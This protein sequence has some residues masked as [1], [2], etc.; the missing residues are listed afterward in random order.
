[1]RFGI[2]GA[3]GRTITV[4][5]LP[6]RNL[7]AYEV[8]PLQAGQ[9]DQRQPLKN[10]GADE[11]RKRE[12]LG[13]VRRLPLLAPASA[14]RRAPAASF[15]RPGI[16]PLPGLIII[17]IEVVT[18]QAVEFVGRER[19][20]GGPHVEPT[21]QT[22]A[23][24]RIGVQ[25]SVLAGVVHQ[26][27]QGAEKPFDARIGITRMEVLLELAEPCAV[28]VEQLD[29]PVLR[30][31]FDDMEQCLVAGG[32][33][34]FL[35]GVP[36]I[37]DTFFEKVVQGFSGRGFPHRSLE[38]ALHGVGH[39]LPLE[40]QHFV[41]QR[42]Q[43]G[44]DDGVHVRGQRMPFAHLLLRGVPPFRRTGESRAFVSAFAVVADPYH[45]GV[46]AAGKGLRFVKDRRDGRLGDFHVFP[47][48]AMVYIMSVEQQEKTAVL[49]LY[50]IDKQRVIVGSFGERQQKTL[51][52]R[53]FRAVSAAQPLRL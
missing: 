50:G 52:G 15:H 18:D 28:H 46:F 33:V 29:G 34:V 51:S 43:F 5:L 41:F 24:E 36:E 40:I 30:E 49:N 7:H 17:C 16:G 6:V 47:V 45:D 38:Y 9:I 39:P 53:G 11:H 20:F 35:V 27:F 12:L 3:V 14:A 32:R 48:Y 22:E 44:T 13:V 42:R 31:P 19:P 2:P 8:L 23:V 4:V 26:C 37:S 25:Q 21:A 10:I 1:M